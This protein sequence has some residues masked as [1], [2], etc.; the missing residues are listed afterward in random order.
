MEEGE[1]GN[2][3]GSSPERC[4]ARWLQEIDRQGAG[5]SKGYAEQEGAGCYAGERLG[6]G[7]EVL[8]VV[9]FEG[10]GNGAVFGLEGG[11]FFGL[12]GHVDWVTMTNSTAIYEIKWI[13]SAVSRGR[14]GGDLIVI[15]G[16]L[17]GCPVGRAI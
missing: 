12:R 9:E 4:V 2:E 16:G 10:C 11:F 13:G 14:V 7:G 17:V 1:D 5:E 6:L 3:E 8:L 15:G